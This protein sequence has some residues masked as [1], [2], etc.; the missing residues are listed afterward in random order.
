[1]IPPKFNFSGIEHAANHYTWTKG[2]PSTLIP[3]T[4]GFW[5]D[6]NGFCHYVHFFTTLCTDITVPSTLIPPLLDFIRI[7]LDLAT[8]FNL[9][10]I[11]IHIY[12][13]I[14]S[15]LLVFFVYISSITFLTRYYLWKDHMP[16]SCIYIWNEW[17]IPFIWP[18]PFTC[19]C[20]VME[21]TC[22]N[23]FIHLHTCSKYESPCR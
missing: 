9:S 10:C 16:H 3:L 20:I 21:H 1:M 8:P 13:R 5:W 6:P 15:N 7:P 14:C 11:H 22:S 18:I 2:P 4:I 12:F 23:T 17:N 19:I